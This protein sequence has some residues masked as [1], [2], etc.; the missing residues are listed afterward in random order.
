MGMS[1]IVNSLLERALWQD[2][3]QGQY[4]GMGISDISKDSTHVG[5][6]CPP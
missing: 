3:E 1:L 5:M 4:L 2:P 6:D